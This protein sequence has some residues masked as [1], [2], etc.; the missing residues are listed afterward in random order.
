[1]SEPHLASGSRE[2]SVLTEVD[3][4]ALLVALVLVPN[5][6]PRNRFYSLYEKPA[7]RRARRRA[8]LLRSLSE[9]IRDGASELSVT[10]HQGY[11]WIRYQLPDVEARRQTKLD[12]DE[13]ALLQL[14]LERA[15]LQTSNP[16]FSE[17]DPC[18]RGRIQQ[19]LLDLLR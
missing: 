12:D 10:R 9:D 13:L 1:M 11:V 5:S 16:I 18:A 8:A 14:V 19:R 6:Y 17:H 4:A 7:A 2:M 15:G 3:A